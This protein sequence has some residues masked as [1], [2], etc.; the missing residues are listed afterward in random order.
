MANLWFIF[1]IIVSLQL[2]GCSSSQ[3]FNLK[4]LHQDFQKAILTHDTSVTAANSDFNDKKILINALRQNDQSEKWKSIEPEANRSFEKI[5][6]QIV[7][8]NRLKA[9]LNELNGQLSALSYS[10]DK[11]NNQDPLW[12]RTVQ[13]NTEFSETS[14]SLTNKIRNYTSESTSL[15]E[16]VRKNNLFVNFD[17]IDF[18]KQ[19]QL[20]IRSANTKIEEM[21][22]TLL[23]FE[24]IINYSEKITDTSQ[25]QGLFDELGQNA[26]NFSNQAQKLSELAARVKDTTMGAARISTLDPNWK[27][28]QSMRLDFDTLKIQLEKFR[29]EFSDKEKA[30]NQSLSKIKS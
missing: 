19:I 16:L 13:I 15:G 26:Q 14:R 22:Q 23:R 2:F 27:Q 1:S 10:R 17:L 4:Q 8:I 20:E 11:V 12:N 5:E 3:T 18:Q 29:K 21:N 28:I 6:L 25:A 9:N 24:K 7:D 30:L